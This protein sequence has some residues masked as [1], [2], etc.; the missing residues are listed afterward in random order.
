MAKLVQDPTGRTATLEIFGFIFPLI[1]CREELC[2]L[3]SMLV[4]INLRVSCS[5]MMNC[6]DL[7]LSYI[8]LF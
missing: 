1:I 2:S 4:P 8:Y 5:D 7:G 3:P 6:L